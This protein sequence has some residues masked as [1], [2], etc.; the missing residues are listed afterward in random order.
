MWFHSPSY[1][2][3]DGPQHQYSQ[4]LYIHLKL[5]IKVCDKLICPLPFFAFLLHSR[6]HSSHF[7]C[8]ILFLF[9]LNIP[10]LRTPKLF[11]NLYLCV[12]FMYITQLC[13]DISI[14]LSMFHLVNMVFME[15]RIFNQLLVYVKLHLQLAKVIPLFWIKNFF[16]IHLA[17]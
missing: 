9:L 2:Y 5:H 4:H 11:I 13:L 1:E 17:L 12:L 6:H 7:Q 14:N 8:P 3:R 10:I 16:H 15:Y